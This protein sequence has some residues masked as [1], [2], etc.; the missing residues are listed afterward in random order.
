MSRLVSSNRLTVNQALF[1][2]T[3]QHLQDY[4]GVLSEERLQEVQARLVEYLGLLDED[5][6]PDTYPPPELDDVPS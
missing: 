4:T 6:G 5:E 3:S 2:S 1:R